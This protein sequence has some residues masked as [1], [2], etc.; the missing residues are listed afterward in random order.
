MTIMMNT[1]ENVGVS[2]CKTGIQ[3]LCKLQYFKYHLCK[4]AAVGNLVPY[5]SVCYVPK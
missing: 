3:D 4:S 1:P 5:N 2:V